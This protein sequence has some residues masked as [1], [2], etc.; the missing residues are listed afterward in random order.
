MGTAMGQFM[1]INLKKANAIGLL[2]LSCGAIAAIAYLCL[3]PGPDRLTS[4]RLP[5]SLQLPGWQPMGRTPLPYPTASER[6][7]VILEAQTYQFEKPSA[8][9]SVQVRYIFNTDS[10][11]SAYQQKWN[12]VRSPHRLLWEY[13]QQKAGVGYYSL[14]ATTQ[15]TVLETC[16]NPQGQT[17]VTRGQFL[18]NRLRYDLN[19]LRTLGW[20]MGS[21]QLLDKRCLWIRLIRQ[22][23]SN[24]P[25]DALPQQLSQ[26]IET[27]T[28]QLTPVL[29][30]SPF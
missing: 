1:P 18:H 30:Q 25:Q 22:T 27:L 4:R 19:P 28:P 26:L 14:S 5:Q 20:A 24:S 6:Y 21:N 15:S 11:L 13:T 3:Q 23:P 10:S 16:I 9:L 2:M 29:Q 8:A 7:D 17:T 12:P